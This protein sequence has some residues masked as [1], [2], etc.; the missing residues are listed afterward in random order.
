MSDKKT[1]ALK[2]FEIQSRPTHGTTQSQVYDWSVFDNVIGAHCAGCPWFNGRQQA[3]E[4]RL[5]LVNMYSI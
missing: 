3:E 2:R 5:A 4:Y 1:S